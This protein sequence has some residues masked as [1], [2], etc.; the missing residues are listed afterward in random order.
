VRGATSQIYTLRVRI[1]V[2]LRAQLDVVAQL[3]DRSGTEEIHL[4]LKDSIERNKADPQV[5][6]RA[7]PGPQK[8]DAAL[9]LV[10]SDVS[11]LSA[12]GEVRAEETGQ[13]GSIGL[14][15]DHLGSQAKRP[16]IQMG[17]Y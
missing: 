8:T 6:K 10:E 14:W 11:F 5:R 17:C 4:P 1:A 2:D 9:E 16:L 7:G 12:R 13:V 15:S 3:T